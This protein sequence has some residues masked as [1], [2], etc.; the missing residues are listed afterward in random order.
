MLDD[1][2][3]WQTDLEVLRLTGSSVEDRG[4]HLVV[5]TPDNPGFHWGSFLLVTDPASVDDADLWV[6]RF[7]ATFP[8]TPWVAVG[9]VRLPDDQRSWNAHGLTVELDDVLSTR[10]LP[11]RTP[12]PDGY[13]V[14]ALAGDDWEQ[15]VL[16]AVA[17]NDRTRE[18]PPDRFERFQ[19]ERMQV[20][21][22]LTERG[23]AA[24]FGAF[25]DGRLVAD[26]GIVRCGTTA[27]YQSVGT[28]AEHRRRGLAG[29]L[30]G[31][32]ASWAADHGCD[33]WVI[34]TE[35]TNPAGRLYRSLGFEPVTGNAQA[36]RKP[37]AEERIPGAGAV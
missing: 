19:R 8:G 2:P 16:V 36:Y 9:L 37:P 26:L 14:R 13:R 21:R 27:R 35:A 32:A 29:H 20:R 18:N 15:H 30:L 34:L 17:E 12:L 28:H 24:F 23:V 33:R 5:R 31:V 10:A 7:E 11:R 25:A 3:G 6:G 1:L 22:A 4:D